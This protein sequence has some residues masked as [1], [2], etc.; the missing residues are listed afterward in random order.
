MRGKYVGFH[1]RFLVIT[2]LRQLLPL[3]MKY[4]EQIMKVTREK[5]QR[6]AN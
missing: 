2:D 3:K 1:H 4:R 5:L 6:L